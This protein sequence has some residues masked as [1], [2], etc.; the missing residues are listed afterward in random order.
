MSVDIESRFGVIMVFP[1]PS[2]FLNHPANWADPLPLPLSLG[3]GKD[4]E[5]ISLNWVSS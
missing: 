1:P 4:V 2:D 5:T 3:V